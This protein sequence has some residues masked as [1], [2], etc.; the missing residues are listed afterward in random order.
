M[1]SV[2]QALLIVDPLTPLSEICHISGVSYG[3]P[4]PL[5]ATLRGDTPRGAWRLIT[6]AFSTV[7][8]WAGKQILYENLFARH[9]GCRIL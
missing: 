8:T 3:G 5:A 1:A 7:P 9:L 2:G 6:W 4:V